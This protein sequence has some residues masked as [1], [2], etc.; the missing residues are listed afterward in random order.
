MPKSKHSRKGEVRRR[1]EVYER[2]RERT[3]AVQAA[4][5]DSKR[6]AELKEALRRI[7]KD[8]SDDAELEN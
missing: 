7:G 4:F 3:R 2:A 5:R 6:D 8:V 1:H